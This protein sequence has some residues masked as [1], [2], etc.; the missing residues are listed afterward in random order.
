MRPSNAS[1]RPRILIVDDNRSVV[2]MLSDTVISLGYD[3]EIALGGRS[4]LAS[5]AA[6]RPDAVL[7]DIRM[8][9]MDGPEV[10]AEIRRIDRD[11]PVLIVTATWDQTT[12]RA[13]LRSGAFDLLHKPVD[14]EYLALALAAALGGDAAALTAASAARLRP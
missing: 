10:L 1:S 14:R 9:G 6:R 8:P 11:V 5:F 3:A 4:A 12:A 2:D 7:L 13:L